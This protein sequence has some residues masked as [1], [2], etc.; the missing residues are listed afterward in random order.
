MVAGV[1]G[2]TAARE[3]TLPTA[4]QATESIG[5][6][7]IVSS[8]HL[9]VPIQAVLGGFKGLLTD[10]GWYRHGNPLLHW[11][12][13]LTLARPHGLQSGCA[14]AGWRRAGP[15]TIG[16]ARVGRGAQNTP[17]RSDIPACAAPRGGNVGLAEALR[18]LIQ[19]WGLAGVGIPGKHLLHHGRLDW[20]KT[21][22]AGIARAVGIKQITR[23]RSS[24]GQKLATAQ[25]GLAPSAHAFG[26]QGPLVLG[27]GGT[28][29]SQELI[30][31]IITHGPLD[32]LD[33]TATLGEC[34]DQEHLMHIVPC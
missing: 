20:V 13:L 32:K 7:R 11:S 6:S 18:H 25:L 24:P 26:N 3:S 4:D 17:Y 19:A 1:Q 15:A 30:R 9:Y 28:D 31:R 34:I 2:A 27:H 22:S 16:N 12:G 23:G 8:G 5:I 33:T 29:L 14:P 21:Y 10:N